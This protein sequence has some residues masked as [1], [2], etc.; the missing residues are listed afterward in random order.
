MYVKFVG[1]AVELVS[2]ADGVNGQPSHG[3]CGEAAISHDGNTVAF[4]CEGSLDP[5]DTNGLVDVYV[6]NVNT[7]RTTLISRTPG[8][9]VGDRDSVD[10]AIAVS[11]TSTFVAFTSSATNLLL[12]QT[13]NGLQQRV[14]RRTIGGIDAMRLMSNNGSPAPTQDD[15]THPSISNDGLRVAFDTSQQLDPADT[16]TVR[17]VY[18]RDFKT[19]PPVSTFVSVPQA[20]GGVD[21]FADSPVISGDGTTVAF[22]LT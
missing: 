17:D 14:Y 15:S 8:G 7:H 20:G 9:A 6:R 21:D 1:G 13:V 10:P 4:T 5:D 22:D 3:D 11:G 18:I 16:N 2:R 12:G 19:V